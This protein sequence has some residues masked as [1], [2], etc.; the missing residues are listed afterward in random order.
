MAKRV[1][2]EDIILINEIYY[3]TKSYAETARQTGWSAGT[4]SKYVD[5]NYAPPAPTEIVRVDMS[6]LPTEFN[7]DIF[8]DL[9]NYG[10]LCV[11]TEEEKN[12]MT[13][14]WKEMKI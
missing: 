6:I 4:V 12:A 1:T 9:D 14:L 7:T 10:E 8:K 13:E 11:L 2:N 3:K 5:K